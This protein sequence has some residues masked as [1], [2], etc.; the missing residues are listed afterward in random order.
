MENLNLEEKLILF[1]QN[2]FL[3][4]QMEIFGLDQI[5]QEEYQNIKQTIEPLAE[6][7]IDIFVDVIGGWIEEHDQENPDVVFEKRYE[8]IISLVE[9]D[10]QPVDYVLENLFGMRHE[11]K[12]YDVL[13]YMDDQDLINFIGD[14]FQVSSEALIEEYRES[15]QEE[16]SEEDKEK[17]QEIE[18][19]DVADYYRINFR[20]ESF[21]KDYYSEDFL[22]NDYVK[23]A[24][25]KWWNDIG[26]YSF[27]N[28][29]EENKSYS[30]RANNKS[31][32]E[33]VDLAKEGLQRLLDSKNNIHLQ[34]EAISLALNLEHNYG[35]IL[36]DH[37]EDYGEEALA[38]DFLNEL[39]NDL[40]ISKQEKIINQ[41][42]RKT[43]KSKETLLQEETHRNLQENYRKQ[44]LTELWNSINKQYTA[45][46][47]STLI[48]LN[49]S[50]YSITK[51]I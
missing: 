10:R 49:C 32:D 11:L 2:E 3:L 40:D 16:E 23:Q 29:I 26:N 51:N 17:T 46:F 47:N 38:F 30:N 12:L 33:I 20:V 37:L 25:N 14:V 45:S 21:P 39:S 4:S 27:F 13:E 24:L 44:R 9:G 35:N 18:I 8:R 19:R 1:H 41:M 31:N 34:A 15:S 36:T 48:K 43:K 28:Q 6:S 42:I 22:E 7:I 50:W 5:F